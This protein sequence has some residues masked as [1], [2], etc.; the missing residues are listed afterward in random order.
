VSRVALTLLVFIAFCELHA[1]YCIGSD[2]VGLESTPSFIEANFPLSLS[3]SLSLSL[4]TK[5]ST[6]HPPSLGLLALKYLLYVLDCALR[7]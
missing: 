1:S 7:L 2:P 4:L 6:K 5:A 3:L